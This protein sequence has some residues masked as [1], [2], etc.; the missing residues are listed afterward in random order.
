MKRLAKLRASL[1]F[2][3]FALVTNCMAAS[4][5]RGSTTTSLVDLHAHFFMPE[6][7]GFPF[8]GGFNDPLHA[9]QWSSRL[10]TR[11][12][13][14]ALTESNVRIAV[15]ALYSHPLFFRSLFGS[16]RESIRTQIR[17]AKAFVT[18]HKDWVIAKSP[19]EAQRALADGKRILILSL[20]G[21]SGVLETDDDIREFI[22]VEGI[23]IVTPLHFIDDWIGGATL[24]P[25]PA[26]LVNPFAALGSFLR[27]DR[28]NIGVLINDSGLTIRG[29]SF[30]TK[31]IEHGVWID[32][33]HASDGSIRQL[34]PILKSA[35]QPIL[36]THTVL[37]S[38]YRAERGISDSMLQEVS[39]SGG[40]VGLLPSDDMLKGTRV[41]FDLCAA[42]CNHHC[43]GGEAAYAT[44]YQAMSK[45]IP[46]SRILIGSDID[47]PISFLKPE[48]E[49]VQAKLPKG[50]WNYAQLNELFAFLR[51]KKLTPDATLGASEVAMQNVLVV[52]FLRAWE[53][54][55]H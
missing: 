50:Y 14:Q 27:S 18:S 16:Q 46:P 42:E 20:E 35:G 1:L 26:L 3:L 24:M 45:V 17:E 51:E 13:A 54:V 4:S 21:A 23:R 10:K 7:S 12:N 52:N 37:R 36:Y 53:K 25:W 39:N 33:S 38:A 47:A 9:S 49:A 34:V 11:V 41:N 5:S 2:W 28:D 43:E 55:A 22:D 44:Q 6:A 19:V 48:C 15:V 29:K 40:I 32:L 30:V 8:F 31:L